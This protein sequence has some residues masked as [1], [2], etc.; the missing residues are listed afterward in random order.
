MAARGAQTHMRVS[1]KRP[2]PAALEPVTPGPTALE[3]PA[4]S[5]KGIDAQ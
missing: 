3:L 4:S 5:L 2:R 1:P